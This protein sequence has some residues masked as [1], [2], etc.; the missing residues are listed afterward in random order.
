MCVC[1]RACGCMRARVSV[2]VCMCELSGCKNF[3]TTLTFPTTQVKSLEEGGEVRKTKITHSPCPLPP[4]PQPLRKILLR[5]RTDMIVPAGLFYRISA[6]FGT[7][8]GGVHTVCIVCITFASEHTCVF[9]TTFGGEHAV[10]YFLPLL[11]VNIQLCIVLAFCLAMGPSV[12]L[13]CQ[14]PS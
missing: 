10:V 12:S 1:A 6:V 8:F 11:A 2:V 3:P 9:C 5:T 7:T 13:L 14:V 4:P